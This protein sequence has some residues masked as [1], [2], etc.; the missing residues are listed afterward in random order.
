VSIYEIRREDGWHIVSRIEVVEHMLG[1]GATPA[2]I[3]AHSVYLEAGF[4]KRREIDILL[5]DELTPIGVRLWS[6]PKW[7]TIARAF[8]AEAT[9]D[10]P[11]PSQENVAKRMKIREETLRRRLRNLDVL[12]WRDVPGLVASEPINARR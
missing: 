6:N 1:Q 7:V 12:R 11:E 8:Q 3:R 5:G 10:V 4:P 9:S 2:E